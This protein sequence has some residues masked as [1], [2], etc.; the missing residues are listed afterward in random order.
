MRFLVGQCLSPDFA[1]ALTAAGHD[2]VHVRDRGM[3]RASDPDVLQLARSEERVVVSADTD[4]GTI[5]AWTS[6]ARPSVVIFRRT[7]GRRP[8]EQATLLLAN[9]PAI[10]QAP[11]ARC[12]QRRRSRRGSLA[13]AAASHHRIG[14]TRVS[15]RDSDSCHFGCIIQSQGTPTC[16]ASRAHLA[17][18]ALTSAAGNFAECSAARRLVGLCMR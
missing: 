9:L 12:R 11:S 10:A 7:T 15:G 8:G 5:L 6:A 18:R 3:Q 17:A 13:S 4:F 16:H 14:P 1:E 2:V